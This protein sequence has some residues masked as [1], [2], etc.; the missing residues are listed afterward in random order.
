MLLFFDLF[1][2]D[3]INII[4]VLF[5]DDSFPN[6]VDLVSEEL[7]FLDNTVHG[8]VR[9][10][11]MSQYFVLTVVRLDSLVI[12]LTLISGTIGADPAFLSNLE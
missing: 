8:W 6:L 1:L 9:E 12:I 4:S 11:P 7:I 2:G 10:A 5:L 3:S